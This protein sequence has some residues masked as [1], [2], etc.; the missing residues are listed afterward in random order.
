MAEDRSSR[1]R[2]RA[3]VIGVGVLLLAALALGVLSLGLAPPPPTPLPVPNGYDDLVAA[4]AAVV[5]AEPAGGKI[6]QATLED[7]RAWVDRNRA[8]LERA[9]LGLAREC[10]V[11][12]R[13]DPQFL[14]G[15]MEAVGSLRRLSRLFQAIATLAEREGRR[16][17]AV[18]GGLDQV[19]LGQQMARGGLMIDE[20]TGLACERP[21]REGLSSLLDRLDADECRTALRALDDLDR[22]RESHEALLA[23]DLDWGFNS[24]GP[25]QRVMYW[26]AASRL[27]ALWQPAA[28]SATS[29]Y[30]RE[31]SRQRALILQLALRLYRIE[32]GKNPERF[33]DL[34]PRYLSSL[35]EDPFGQGLLYSSSMLTGELPPVTE[36]DEEGR[37][38]GGPPSRAR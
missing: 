26:L 14:P 17:E 18:R 15:H 32:Q 11:P 19:R 35:P 6:A 24:V 21:G 34:V 5:G 3:I 13:Y 25:G 36:V 16:A 10:R 31:V 12:V 38:R 8:P 4:G 28:N 37:T 9:R 7:L 1:R 20:M 23:R 29:T 33:S 30:K 2:L 27:K 22:S